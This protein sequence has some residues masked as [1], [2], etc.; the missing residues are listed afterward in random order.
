MYASGGNY[1]F[2]LNPPASF[3]IAT[4]DVLVVSKI[5]PASF[6]SPT[7]T[8]PGS[9]GIQSYNLSS[10]NPYTVYYDAGC[11]DGDYTEGKALIIQGNWTLNF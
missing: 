10:L 9:I 8:R 4:G 5:F 6:N 7:S 11:R 1:N 2:I 3:V